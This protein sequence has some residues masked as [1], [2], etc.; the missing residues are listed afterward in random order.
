LHKTAIQAITKGSS[1]Y[2]EWLTSRS[3]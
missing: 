2:L 3:S 1:F